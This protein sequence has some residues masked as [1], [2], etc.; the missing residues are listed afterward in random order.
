ML[1][2]SPIA[3]QTIYTLASV[4][5]VIGA[6]IGGR[7]LVKGIGFKGALWA[8][9]F[10]FLM[11]A[12]ALL[13]PAFLGEFWFALVISFMAAGAMIEYFAMSQPFIPEF[14]SKIDAY[15]RKTGIAL[16][17]CTPMLALLVTEVAR[18]LPDATK[19][20]VSAESYFLL[21]VIYLIAVVLLPIALQAVSSGTMFQQTRTFFGLMCL[22]WT[23]GQLVLLRSLENGF[24]CMVLFL[25]A[26]A[27]NDIAAYATGKVIGKTRFSP[28][29]SP[30]KTWE[31]F[32]G[33]VLGTALA[34]ALFNYAVPQL[35]LPHLI[36]FVLLLSVTGPLGDL[37]ISI[38]KRESG[39]KDTGNAI[40]G[41]GGL[42]DRFDSM[43][44]SAP[45]AF[46]YIRF[47]V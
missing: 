43:I 35:E 25:T 30:N 2:A 21:P 34:V 19:V 8:R 42:L 1:S 10:G 39:I 6:L 20:P 27:F 11:I 32:T 37:T 41:H 23:I 13:I 4:F 33:G 45:L 29:V 36:G 15:F 22:A 38:L 12:P 5:V 14:D 28:V 3:L 17:F 46:L 18:Q 26:W 16:A 7:S 47:F 31:G 40:P 24:G 9:Y 44:F